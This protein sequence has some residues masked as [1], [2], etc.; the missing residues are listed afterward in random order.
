M[1]EGNGGA[2]QPEHAGES[3]HWGVLHDQQHLLNEGLLLQLVDLAFHQDVLGA[4][5]ADDEGGADDGP[6]V[7]L[8]PA[9]PDVEEEQELDGGL[10]VALGG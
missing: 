10:V 2:A 4:N 8:A 9:Q 3:H 1:V 6:E 7:E 5:L